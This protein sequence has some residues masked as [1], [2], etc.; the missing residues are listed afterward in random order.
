MIVFLPKYSDL[1]LED[2]G[3]SSLKKTLVKVV[4]DEF[5]FNA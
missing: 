4:Q 3:F 1:T 5:G 2:D